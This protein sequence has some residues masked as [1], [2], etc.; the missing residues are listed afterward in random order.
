MG[1][2]FSLMQH[3]IIRHAHAVDLV[4]DHARTLSSKG[5]SQV[6]RLAEFLSH[7]GDFTPDEIWHSPLVRA[8]ET[9]MLLAGPL[10]LTQVVKE[11]PGLLPDSDPHVMAAA[12]LESGRSIAVVGHE[13]HLGALASLLVTGRM[14]RPVVVMNTCAALAV[15]GGGSFWQVRWHLLPELFV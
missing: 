8:R 6:A 15:D 1:S 9:A 14:A 4:P 5:R 11:A 10:K 3:Y 13:P 12:L 7:G 2:D